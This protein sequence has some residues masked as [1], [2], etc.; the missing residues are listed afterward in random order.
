MVGKANFS[1]SLWSP[2]KKIL[3]VNNWYLCGFDNVL[4]LVLFCANPLE[5][6]DH[7][8]FFQ[9]FNETVR[10]CHNPLVRTCSDDVEGPE[11]CNTYYETACETTYK[12]YEVEQDEPVCRM[13][14]MTKC[15]DVKC[16]SD[17]G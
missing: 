1:S 16:K 5:V 10:V 8:F 15:E 7:W 17:L 14:I 12:T 3:H 13:E 4:I 6:N 9:P 2:H 11:I